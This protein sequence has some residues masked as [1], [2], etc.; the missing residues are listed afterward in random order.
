MNNGDKIT[1]RRKE[2]VPA[3]KEKER[4]KAIA[5]HKEWCA[6]NNVPFF[7]SENGR[8]PRCRGDVIAYYD[9]I[10]GLITGCP[11]CNASYTD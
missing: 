3:V 7:M 9:G 2:A 5:G 6:L 8:C 1:E 4:L 11:Y 10:A